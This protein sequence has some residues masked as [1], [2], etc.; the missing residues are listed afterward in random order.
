MNRFYESAWRAFAATSVAAFLAVEALAPSASA[1][2]A[3]ADGEIDIGIIC[4]RGVGTACKSG[5]CL[6]FD[7]YCN[8]VIH[9]LGYCCY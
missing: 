8:L 2:V 4:R 9:P 5:F 7:G 6:P 3:V 1:A